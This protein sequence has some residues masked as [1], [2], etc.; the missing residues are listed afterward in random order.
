MPGTE[1]AL[2]RRVYGFAYDEG[3]HRGVRDVLYHRVRQR[4]GEVAALVRAD[5]RIRVAH[6]VSILAPD[7]RCSPPRDHILLW[8]LARHGHTSA[9]D[10]AKLLGIPVRTAQ[11]GLRRLADDGV[12]RAEKVGRRLEYHLEDTT[13]REPTQV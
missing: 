8:L 2:F 3:L 13:F 6:D 1:D 11:D 12:C 7:P 9:K 5:G 10:A 4:L